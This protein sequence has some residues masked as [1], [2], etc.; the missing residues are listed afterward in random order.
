MTTQPRTIH[1]ME[2]ADRALPDYIPSVPRKPKTSAVSFVVSA[3]S[4]TWKSAVKWKNLL[5]AAL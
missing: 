3:G 1:E 5:T 4:I 2:A